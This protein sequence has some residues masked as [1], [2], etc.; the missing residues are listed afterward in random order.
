MSDFPRIK[1]LGLE[2]TETHISWS[3]GTPKPDV[4]YNIRA[5]DL[6]RL[7]SQGVRVYVKYYESPKI[8]VARGDN[9]FVGEQATHTA[10]LIGTKPIVRDTAESLL[11][12]FV[13]KVEKN[14]S[15]MA[16]SSWDDFDFIERAR[17]LVE[18]EK[19]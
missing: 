12:E 10:F 5:A 15:L 2:V 16:A 7:L 19:K 11:R 6:E 1:E 14:A 13:K 4:V 3:G 9:G 18:R 8:I 17:A